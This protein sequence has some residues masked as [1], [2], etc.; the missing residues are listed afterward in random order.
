LDL[1]SV[2]RKLGKHHIE[3]LYGLYP[4]LICCTGDQIKEDEMGRACGTHGGE[5]KCLSELFGRAWK[6]NM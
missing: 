6:T 3:E 2:N 5:E 4:S 1:I